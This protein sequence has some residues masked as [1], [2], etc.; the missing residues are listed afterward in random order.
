LFNELV[1]VI[2]RTNTISHIGKI[3]NIVGLAIE[4]SGR[5]ASI[6][7]ISMIYN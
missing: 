4:A 2:K 3:E 1:D 6:G 5:K 7:E